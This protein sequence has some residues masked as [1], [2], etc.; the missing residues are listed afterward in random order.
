M[1]RIKQKIAAG[2]VTSDQ[3]ITTFIAKEICQPEQ[4]SKEKNRIIETNTGNP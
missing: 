1:K 3:S 4:R 2:P